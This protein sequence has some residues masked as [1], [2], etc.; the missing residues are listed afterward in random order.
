MRRSGVQKEDGGGNGPWLFRAKEAAPVMAKHVALLSGAV[1]EETSEKGSPRGQK[2]RD[3]ARPE[4]GRRDQLPYENKYGNGVTEN[5]YTVTGV[6]SSDAVPEK[7][8]MLLNEKTFYKTY[9][10]NLPEDPGDGTHIPG[11]KIGTVP[12][13]CAG[14]EAAP[15]DPNP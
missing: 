5:R 11:E 4:E 13:F 8:I 1:P 9:L 3:V 10:E 14:M 7:N 12:A 2:P 6:F 15:A